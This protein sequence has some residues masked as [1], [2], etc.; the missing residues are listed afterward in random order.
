MSDEDKEK[1]EQI[2]PQIGGKSYEY[3]DEEEQADGFDWE[4]DSCSEISE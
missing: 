2:D 4:L 1:V 3:E